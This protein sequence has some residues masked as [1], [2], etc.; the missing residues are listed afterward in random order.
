[1]IKKSIRLDQ[2]NGGKEM[3]VL[4]DKL[5]KFLPSS[6]W[7]HSDDDSA[8]LK[9]DIGFFGLT[10]DS[11]VVD[12]VFFPGG[13]I[14]KIAM[15]GTI[16]DLAVMGIKA[17]AV[18]LGLVVE[19]GFPEE[20]L[21]QIM[22]SIGDVSRKTGVPVVTG[23]TK[24]MQKGKLDKIIINTSGIGITDTILD[25]PLVPGDKI[26]LSGSLGD[27]AIAVLSQ[28]FDFQTSVVTDS[29]PLI[30]EVFSVKEFIKQA[31]DPTRGGLASALNEFAEK[32]G[33][34]ILIDEDSV[35]VKKE[36]RSAVELL[37]IDLYSLACEG[38]LLCVVSSEHASKVIGVLKGFNPEAA[39][40]GEIFED[41]PGSRP[42]VVVKTRFGKRF[43][44]MPSGNIVPRI[45]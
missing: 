10:T 43:L 38:R 31:K 39:I 2:G 3:N 24:V 16:N 29:K 25:K 32:S 22:E 19:E 27:H 45:C 9:T 15:C 42:K 1:M 28:R 12:P 5:K 36:V 7:T 8:I 40:I 13:N 11:F 44:P 23:D 30:D 17:S 21:L 20:D 4:I 33:L 14:G 18:S 35:P 41:A 26:I 34:S 6:N 37:G